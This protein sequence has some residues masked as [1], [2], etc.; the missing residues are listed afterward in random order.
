M[1]LWDCSNNL[2][3]MEPKTSTW[4]SSF[5]TQLDRIPSPSLTETASEK[6]TR[7]PSIYHRL[8]YVLRGLLYVLL[9]FLHLIFIFLIYVVPGAIA[10]II[11]AAGIPLAWIAANGA[12]TMLT[13]NAILRTHL[14]HY[15]NNATAAY[16]GS[17]E[18]LIAS[19]CI[20]PLSLVLP[21]NENG[22]S[23]WCITIPTTV[24]YSTFT[25]AIGSAVLHHNH[26]DLHESDVL[27]ATRAG[28]VGGACLDQESS[29]LHP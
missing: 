7:A 22:T 12:V 21:R 17:V 1:Y 27:H 4:Q 2:L 13:G 28:A 3:I 15:T 18:S 8:K 25:G 10:V 19:I 5:T 26:V 14:A 24:V 9:D 16:I 23:P 20:T 29:L 11:F 6:I